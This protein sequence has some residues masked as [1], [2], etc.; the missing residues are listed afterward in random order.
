M[1]LNGASLLTTLFAIIVGFWIH[2]EYLKGQPLW[3]VVGG[4]LAFGEVF[5]LVT[6]IETFPLQIF[7]KTQVG[8]QLDEAVS[9]QIAQQSVS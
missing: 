3:I 1:E 8:S 4:T 9:T 5:K 7:K 6:G 2:R